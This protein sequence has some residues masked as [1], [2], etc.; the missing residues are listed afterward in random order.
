MSEKDI[1][2]LNAQTFF[3][4]RRDIGSESK[5][6]LIG[7]ALNKNIPLEKLSYYNWQ[8]RE[9]IKAIRER[10]ET[11]FT[12][13]WETKSP[14]SQWHKSL[15]KSSDVSFH[16]GIYE[17]Q[18]EYLKS[19]LPNE[20]EFS[21]AE[22]F[23]MY[24]KA[25]IFLDR[26]IADKILNTSNPRKLKE[27][28]RQVKNYDDDIWKYH[29]SNVIYAANKAKFSQAPH[30]MD[31]LTDTIGTTLVEAAPNDQIWG[32]GLVADDPKAQQ[33]E[34][35]EGKNLLGEILTLLRMEFMGMY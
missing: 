22:Q 5:E 18:K 2:I 19:S 12:F 1:E 23:M 20:L 24:H 3:V 21:S 28:G 10:D 11:Q 33:R 29:R 27:L 6:E 17:Q 9:L 35:W 26:E 31:V 34:T 30:L 14:F 4:N 8:D 13:F 16:K 32:I 7:D 25:I 15:F